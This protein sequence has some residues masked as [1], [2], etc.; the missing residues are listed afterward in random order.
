MF[1]RFQHENLIWKGMLPEWALQ[2]FMDK[3]SLD[4]A[5]AIK[6]LTDQACV[7]NAQKYPFDLSF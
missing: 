3:F 7:K 4:R 6:Q 5:D 2:I 1:F